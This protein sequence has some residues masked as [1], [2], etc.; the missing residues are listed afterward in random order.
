MSLRLM[1]SLK[2]V[3]AV[4]LIIGSRETGG[5]S[6][7]PTTAYWYQVLLRKRSELKIYVTTAP[8]SRERDVGIVG[9][10]TR[11][12]QVTYTPRYCVML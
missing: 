5:R 6:D 7:Y 11:L 4:P 3:W 9:T 2:V 8:T 10:A 12:L 1:P